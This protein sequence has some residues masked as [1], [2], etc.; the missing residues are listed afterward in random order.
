M[1]HRARS[2]SVPWHRR[3]WR[4]GR[5]AA[6][7][8][9][10]LERAAGFEHVQH[11]GREN[12]LAAASTKKGRSKFKEPS[13]RGLTLLLPA[14]SKSKQRTDQ[15]T[16]NSH[17]RWTDERGLVNAGLRGRQGS[18]RRRWLPGHCAQRRARQE[19]PEP[20]ISP[21]LSD[22]RDVRADRCERAHRRLG[23]G[24]PSFGLRMKEVVRRGS[25]VPFVLMSG[26]DSNGAR[27]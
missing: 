21:W 27:E 22:T 20:C 3:H 25:P 17:K 26:S 14:G 13:R 16:P 10:G 11:P 5:A 15:S 2:R 7:V 9:A 24:T 8:P 12:G 6:E 4:S 18:W 19:R 1:P 23:D